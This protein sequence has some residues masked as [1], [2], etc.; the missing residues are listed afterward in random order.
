MTFIEVISHPVQMMNLTIFHEAL[1][2]HVRFLP[3]AMTDDL[4]LCRAMPRASVD[5]AG[6][7]RAAGSGQR[8]SQRRLPVQ[9]NGQLFLKVLVLIAD[10]T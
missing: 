5:H 4:V 9:M 7:R 6:G 3:D 10:L 8:A 1:T 2:R